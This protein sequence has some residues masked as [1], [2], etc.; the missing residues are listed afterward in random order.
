M[1]SRKRVC[2]DEDL[3]ALVGYLGEIYSTVKHMA[4]VIPYKHMASGYTLFNSNIRGQFIVC[5][6]WETKMEGFS[7]V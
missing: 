1:G 7:L 2:Q 5:R 6:V 3:V 4:L